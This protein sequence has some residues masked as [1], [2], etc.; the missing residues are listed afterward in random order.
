MMNKY[1]LA[2]AVTA[3]SL[4]SSGAWAHGQG[5]ATSE[6][7]KDAQADQQGPVASEGAASAPQQG[8]SDEAATRNATKHPPTARMDRAMPTEKASPDA[9]SSM[10]PPT[11]R[12]NRATPAEK[13]PGSGSGSAEERSPKA[14]DAQGQSSTQRENARPKGSSSS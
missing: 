7:A 4:A 14:D 10:H 2:L 5:A 12:M 8:T 1:R 13:S 6:P 3:L 9:D 11:G